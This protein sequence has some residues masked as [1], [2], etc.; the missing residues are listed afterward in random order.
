MK[1]LANHL[2]FVCSACN[3]EFS[4]EEFKKNKICKN[5]GKFLTL[6]NK[7]TRPAE[8]ELKGKGEISVD[9]RVT[10]LLELKIDSK[11]LVPSLEKEA[12]ILIKDD[13]FAFILVAVLDRGTKA[14]IIWTIPYYIT[15]LK[16][17]LEPS[18][19]ANASLN[20][21]AQIVQNLPVRPRYT[22]DAPRTMQE[23]SRIIVNEFGG[24]ASKLWE[25]RS[26]KAVEATVRRVYGVGPGIASMITLLLERW[27][28]V[29]FNDVDH[30]GMDV[31]P[32]VHVIRVFKRLGFITESNSQAALMAARRLNPD[33]PG[34][35]DPP[36][37][38]IGRNYCNANSPKCSRC[39]M[40]SCCPKLM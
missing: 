30:R 6:E 13:P 39:P 14:E 19:F 21:L 11:D 5:C 2:Y 8:G 17:S 29:K 32:D 16:G 22:N 7:R 25:N 4:F 28:E 33:Y 3:E 34:A 26:S 38:M 10:K 18:Y 37:W 20:E 35:L 1:R 31:K 15:R 27:F 12:S 9:S 23:L 40:D 24:D 36:T